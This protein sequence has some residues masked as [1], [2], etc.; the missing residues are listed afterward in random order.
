[1]MRSRTIRKNLVSQMVNRGRFYEEWI[2][3]A[4]Q[5]YEA[6]GLAVIK[7]IPTPWQ[8]QRKYN[9][10][11]RTYEIAYA[12]PERKSTV[13]FGGTASAQSIWFDAKVTENKTSFPLKNIHDHQVDYLEK[14]YK[15]G[16]MAFFLVHFTAHNKSFLLW[17]SDLFKFRAIS[18][19]KSI[20]YSWFE[21]NCEVIS[22]GN[23][24]TL[25]Y[26]P[27]VLS[28]KDG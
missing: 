21:E 24:V 23:G 14:V 16:G 12:F 5:V 7:K 3:Q 15:Q 8:V 2:D 20:P 6:K 11:K 1:M 9:Q 27:A 19:R 10:Y 17:L 4:N 22:S 28:R 13:D 25:D 18:A 26:L